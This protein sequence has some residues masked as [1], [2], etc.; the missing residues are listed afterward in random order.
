MSEK[1]LF[2]IGSKTVIKLL[3][4]LQFG[5]SHFC[6][7]NFNYNFFLIWI[8]LHGCWRFAGQQWK[9]VDHPSP[10]SSFFFHILTNIEIFLL[11][12]CIWNA[13]LMFLIAVQVI[14]RLLLDK[15]YLP[16]GISFQW[17]LNIRYISFWHMLLFNA[18]IA[19]IKSSLTNCWL[20]E[21]TLIITQV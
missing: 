20:F 16:M 21:L 10:S 4:R 9:G 5:L 13:Y 15:I 19:V 17:T 7:D 3:V 12:L 2:S 8:F 6:Q 18:I 14:L 11:H 1:N